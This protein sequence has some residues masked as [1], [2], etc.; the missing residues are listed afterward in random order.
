MAKGVD[1][2]LGLCFNGQVPAP[3]QLKTP[4]MP[5]NLFMF[6]IFSKLRIFTIETNDQK[7]KFISQ[8]SFNA[9]H[10]CVSLNTANPDFRQFMILWTL[11]LGDF[12]ERERERAF[13]LFPSMTG[14]LNK[15]SR[16]GRP[17]RLALRIY[18]SG[19]TSF[20]SSLKSC[21]PGLSLQSHNHLNIYIQ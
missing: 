11:A 21:I 14:S 1:S 19:S 7:L 12:S 8:E 18:P 13:Y 10:F 5:E 15:Q 3:W 17:A 2:E 20:L 16:V 4:I 6:Q 9:K